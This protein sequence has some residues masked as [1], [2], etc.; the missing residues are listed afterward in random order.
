MSRSNK[1]L[2]ALAQMLE[3]TGDD[4][5][6]LDLVQRAQRFKRSWVE[7]AEALTRLRN[8]RSYEAW[9][10]ASL[11]EYCAKEL[12]ITAATVDKLVLS[13]ATVT[14]HAPG[15]LRHDGVAHIIPSI[16]AVDYFSRALGSDER[17][18]PFRRLDAADDAV[19]QLR[20]A[21]FDQGQSVR[22]LR[23]RWNPVL[24]AKPEATDAEELIRKTRATAEKLSQLLPE[25]DGLT[26]ARVGRVL[27]ALEVLVRDLD[28]LE[29]AAQKPS[30]KRAPKH[31][32]A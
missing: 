17:P 6:R 12:S 32:Q 13:F 5:V 18:G 22:E 30:H 2:D 28:A 11:H 25:I 10:Y 20:A 15:V 24:H 27:A 9:G 23:E 31:A 1:K 8:S 29:A 4:P 14:R 16:D 7:L 3:R 21:V 26:E 19:E